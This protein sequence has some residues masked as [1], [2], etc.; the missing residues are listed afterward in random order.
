MT[1]GKKQNVVQVDNH[2]LVN[3]VSLTPTLSETLRE[4][5]CWAL[6]DTRSDPD[7]YWMLFSI[8][9]PLGREP[10]DRHCGGW[11]CNNSKADKSRGRRY[12][13]LTVI[14]LILRSQCRDGEFCPFSQ[15]RKNLHWELRKPAP[16]R[17]YSYMTLCSGKEGKQFL[18][19]EI[20]S[21]KLPIIPA[22]FL[23]WSWLRLRRN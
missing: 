11:V 2:K 5:W 8:R 12:L 18:K 16:K 9:F 21:Q 22:L 13:F 14:V 17:C 3:K 23:F 7:E 20:W 6:Q 15:Q 1:F 19:G 10:S 4:C